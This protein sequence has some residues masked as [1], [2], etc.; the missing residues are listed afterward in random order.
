MTTRSSVRTKILRVGIIQGGKIVEERHVRRPDSV[1]VGQDAKNT[2]VIPASN[3][4]PTFPVFD[5]RGTHYYLLFTERM[6]GRVRIGD[7]D[8]D[9]AALRSQKLAQ[10]RGSVYA[11]QLNDTAKGKVSLGEVTLLFQFVPPPPA[12]ARMALPA[13]FRGTVWSSMD[14]VFFAILV[15]SVLL[16][17]TGAACI[18]L[19]PKPPDSDVTLDQLPD[20]FAKLLVPPK[21][22]EPEKKEEPKG[23]EKVE[24]KEAKK[25]EKPASEEAR[26]AA[27]A[28]KVQSK[29]ILK[30]LGASGGQG[31]LKD[32]LGESTGTQDVA[33]AL[34][35][36]Q[37]GL[38]VATTGGVGGPR[39]GG[40]GSAAGIGDVGTSGGGNV[41]LG[42][43]GDAR[44]TGKV[45]A[46][47]PEV[48]SAD[49]DREALARYI[50]ARLTAI[51]GCYEKELKRN[52]TLKGKVVVRF[53]ITPA[54]RA[55]DIRIEE[56]SVGSAEVGL[57]IASLMRSWVFPFKPPDE[58]AVQYPF[59]FTASQ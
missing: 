42:N 48:D 22:P 15:A 18:A 28:Q 19:T 57:C 30:I 58:V 9:F 14:H 13:E 6:E 17:F 56:N 39:G 41:S 4:P 5:F 51:R 11:L 33:S 7:R 2:F 46:A 53:N 20:R 12:P 47:S 44:V 36:A 59:L 34:K 40:A 23:E 55:G 21:A 27:I 26:K 32:L 54:G 38:V 37:G 49:V 31:A 10:K 29:G 25:K 24:K 52:P 35:G 3:L 16:N 1:S 45:A 50:K 43:K 8:L